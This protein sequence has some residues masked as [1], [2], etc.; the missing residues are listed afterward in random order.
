M[1]EEVT[2]GLSV[3]KL[4]NDNKNYQCA[5]Q[6]MIKEVARELSVRKSHDD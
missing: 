4:H 3:R 5:N 2:E 6:T 1:I